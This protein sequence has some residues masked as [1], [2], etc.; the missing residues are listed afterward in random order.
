[1]QQI[2]AGNSEQEIRK[3]WEPQLTQFK[4]IRKRYL[5]YKDFE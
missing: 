1:M 3:T 5:L 2:K 4:E